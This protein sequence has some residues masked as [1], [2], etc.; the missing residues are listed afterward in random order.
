MQWAESFAT[1]ADGKRASI[2]GLVDE[3]LGKQLRVYKRQVAKRLIAANEPLAHELGL[4]DLLALAVLAL[5]GES[6][7]FG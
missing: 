2:G 3:K 6:P 4:H 1:Y 5:E 7:R